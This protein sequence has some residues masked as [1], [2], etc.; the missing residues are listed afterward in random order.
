MRLGLTSHHSLDLHVSVTINHFIVFLV[1]SI[2]VGGRSKAV[3]WMKQSLYIA[4]KSSTTIHTGHPAWRIKCALTETNRITNWSNYAV[5]RS[6]LSQITCYLVCHVS[7]LSRDQHHL[8]YRST[9]LIAA[10][11]ANG[12]VSSV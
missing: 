3:D 12:V 4:P 7:T 11:P 6:K 2:G 1:S 9:H 5:V 10:N 8:G